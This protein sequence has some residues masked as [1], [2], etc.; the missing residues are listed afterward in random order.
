MNYNYIYFN[1]PD[2]RLYT[3]KEGYFNVC[4]R[5]LESMPGVMVVN[6]P[7]DWASFPIRFLFAVH[8]S[9]LINKYVK[10][11]FKRIWYPKY[12]KNPFRDDK[13][14]CF[15]IQNVYLSL[16][17]FQYLKKR[18]PSSRFVLINR[19]LL[20]VALKSNQALVNSDLPDIRM[21]IDINESE[22]FN[23]IHFDEFESKIDIPQ[24]KD[25]PLYDVFFAGHA[26]DRLPKLVKTYD[27]LT[28]AGLKC[29]F[30]ITGAT[31]DMQIIREGI[32]YADKQMPYTKM[33][34]YSVN[35]RCILEYNYGNAVGYTSRFLE[36]V[37]YNKK[38]ITDNQTIKD[39][40]FYNPEFISC[41]DRPED[42]RPQFVLDNDNNVN[43]HYIDGFSPKYLIEKIDAILTERYL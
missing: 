19:D 30:Y 39:S 36:A 9:G 37:M 31:K 6:N 28:K 5:D 26:K 41:I 35:S 33:L 21:S 13:P 11:P 16:D 22:K 32:F 4:T 1:S 29:F 14:I 10:L 40:K 18:Y 27:I 8:N 20:A 17:Y 15:V 23:M 24:S 34:Y 12:F 43:Y 3:N 42:I 2:H 38:L 7:Y 25:Y